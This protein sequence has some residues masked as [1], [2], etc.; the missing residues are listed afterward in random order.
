M[1]VGY[2]TR[3]DRIAVSITGR[4]EPTRRGRGRQAGRQGD[5]RSESKKKESVDDRFVGIHNSGLSW[6]YSKSRLQ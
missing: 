1:L 4:M 3:P 5:H 2:S 6:A